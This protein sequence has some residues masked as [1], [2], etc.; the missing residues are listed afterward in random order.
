MP[1]RSRDWLR[2]A[3]YDLA[4]AELAAQV[5]GH[6]WACFAAHQAAEK[7]VQAMHFR[8]IQAACGHVVADLLRDLPAELAVPP[9]LIAEAQVLDNYYIPTRYPDTHAAGA[10]YEHYN[11]LHSEQA[12]RY[13]REIVEFARHALAQT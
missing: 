13:A 10:A 7:A 2:Q 3:E 11:Q 8:Y 9:E 12:V 5:G 4:H 6:S 1:N